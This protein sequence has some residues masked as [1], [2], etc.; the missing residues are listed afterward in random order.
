MFRIS[1]RIVVGLGGLVW[2]LASGQAACA[3]TTTLA[4]DSLPSAQGWTYV[5]NGAEHSTFSLSGGLLKQHTVG[6]GS[7]Y[8][9]YEKRGVVD[10]TKPFVMKMRA[11]VTAED[12]GS[13]YGL[14]FGQYTG[15]RAFFFGIAGG[16]LRNISG[17][18]L[19]SGLN[20]SEFHDYRVEGNFATDTYKL[21]YD[22]TLISQ[23]GSAASGSNN[24]I[25]FGD[26]TPTGSNANAEISMVTF[27][28]AADPDP[29]PDPD[30]E[31]PAV[32]EPGGLWL[33]LPAL[34]AVVALRRKRA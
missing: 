28:Q 9:W 30:P 20:M 31:T 2:W 6:F 26:G 13:D 32:P 8:S 7:I 27:E 17:T 21:Y 14:S 18:V 4:F 19:A 29:D 11:R 33:F 24:C 23:G 15:T 3:Q 10:P 5:S 12:R 22:N 34:G 1:N 16:R 25:L